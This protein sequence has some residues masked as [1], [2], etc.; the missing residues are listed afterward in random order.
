MYNRNFMKRMLSLLIDNPVFLF[1]FTRLIR[2][3]NSE[4]ML[5]ANTSLCEVHGYINSTNRGELLKLSI[6]RIL[7][8]RMFLF[9]GQRPLNNRRNLAIVTLSRSFFGNEYPKISRTSISFKYEI[10]GIAFHP[11]APIFA[12]SGMNK[13]VIL[14]LLYPDGSTKRLTTLAGHTNY[15]CSIAFHPTAPFLATGSGDKTAKLWRL[16]PDCS[17]ATCVATLA[18]HK[19]CVFSVA[20]HPTE[21]ILVTGSRDKTAKLWR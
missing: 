5:P 13:K 16:S 3:M 14:L 21:P 17:A 9:R 10:F 7:L 1:K 20:F 11:N 12:T 2:Q 18:G 4:K 19:K 6:I 8:D 15:V